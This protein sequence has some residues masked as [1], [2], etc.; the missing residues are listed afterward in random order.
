[1]KWF[2]KPK[3]FNIGLNNLGTSNKHEQNE[4]TPFSKGCG[5]N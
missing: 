3:Y 4:T 2:V 1:M 5:N